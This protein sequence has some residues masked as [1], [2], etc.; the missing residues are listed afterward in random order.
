MA[1]CSACPEH[2]QC[3]HSLIPSPQDDLAIWF[4]GKDDAYMDRYGRGGK[5]RHAFTR[6]TE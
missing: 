1:L 2:V 4:P 6:V 3:L 5:V